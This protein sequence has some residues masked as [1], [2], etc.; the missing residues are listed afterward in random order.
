MR[1]KQ[2]P[3]HREVSNRW[4]IERRF[5]AVVT[6]SPSFVAERSDNQLVSNEPE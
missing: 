1:R 3:A 4:V 5:L 6:H 2:P